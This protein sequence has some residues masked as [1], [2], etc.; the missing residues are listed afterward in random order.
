MAFKPLLDRRT[1]RVKDLAPYAASVLKLYLAF[2][3]GLARG[4]VGP[5]PSHYVD[6]QYLFYAPFCMVFASSDRFHRAMWPAT[7]GVN[8]FVWG[9]D[10]K[11]DL[12]ARVAR[13]KAQDE[14]A[15]DAEAKEYGF[16][17]ADQDGSVINALWKKYMRPRQ[18]ILPSRSEAKTIDDLE[19]EI[20]D[21]LRRIIKMI[22][23][24]ES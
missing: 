11:A 21:E 8:T 1:L 7:S 10:L 5:R 12:A 19:P 6:L 4:F 15:R 2:V 9:P 13:R 16:Y 18:E 22:P 24:Q 20:R 23:G 14:G 3:G 17:P